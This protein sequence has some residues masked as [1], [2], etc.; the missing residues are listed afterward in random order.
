M[1]VESF[2]TLCD[3]LDAE[4]SEVI[5]EISAI[6]NMRT[7]NSFVICEY[8]GTVT[9][10]G[11]FYLPSDA[12]KF[13][14]AKANDQPTWTVVLVREMPSDTLISHVKPSTVAA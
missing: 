12:V 8:M 14:I 11:M 3:K 10:L 6:D 13:A 7:L 2:K 4:P 5:A 1:T 9:L